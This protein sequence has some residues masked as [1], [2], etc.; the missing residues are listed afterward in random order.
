MHRPAL[1]HLRI[2]AKWTTCKHIQHT[3]SSTSVTNWWVFLL[4]NKIKNE[5]VLGSE[6][7]EKEVAASVGVGVGFG[8]GF[9][10]GAKQNDRI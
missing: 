2:V 1:Y 9:G 3:K 4:V 5:M 7:I 6:T 10:F 8:F